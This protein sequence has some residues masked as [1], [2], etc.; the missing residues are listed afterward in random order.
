MSRVL[1]L[2]WG[3]PSRGDDAIGPHLLKSL[4]DEA[5]RRPE[6]R[7]HVFVTDFQL[8]PEHALDL[9]GA[10]LV[11]F[12]DA[13]VAAPAPWSFGRVRAARDRSF[14]THAMSPAALLAVHESLGAAAPPAWLLAVHGEC[15]ELG[16][17]LGVA[18]GANA[19]AALRV[20]EDL[21]SHPEPDYWENVA[22]NG[23]GAIKA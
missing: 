11:L 22:S 2:A 4:E 1:V 13:S 19:E 3:N 20:A 10:D 14:S 21:L 9:D 7:G 6:W 5:A 12:I 17:P 23:G 16:A 8:Q 15:F 18:A